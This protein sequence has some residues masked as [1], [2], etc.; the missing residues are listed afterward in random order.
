MRTRPLALVLLLVL[1]CGAGDAQG[2]GEAIRPWYVTNIPDQDTELAIRRGGE[3]ETIYP[4]SYALLV[5]QVNY[6][7]WDR[8]TAVPGEIASLTKA[9]ERQR[10]K[11]E[12]H[13][14]LDYRSLRAVID[15]F[16]QTRG[17]E[18]GSRLVIYVSGHGWSRINAVARPMGYILPVDAPP[19]DAPEAELAAKALPMTHFEAWAKAPDPRHMLFV[20][21]SCF[22]GAFFGF[23]G[24]PGTTSPGSGAP[25]G[26]TDWTLDENG[27]LVPPPPD[28]R[29]IE[30][31]DY[32]DDEM[33]RSSGRQFLAAG[34]STQTVPGRS[35]LTQ[36]LIGILDDRNARAQSNADYWTTADEFGPWIRH[37]ATDLSRRLYGVQLPPRPVYG[38]LPNDSFYQQGDMIF[39]RNDLPGSPILRSEALAWAAAEK[40]AVPI[41]AILTKG[42]SGPREAAK[43]LADAK[44]QQAALVSAADAA[45]PA[46]AD[47]LTDADEADLRRLIDALLLD[48]PVRRR[49]AR[50]DLASWLGGLPPSKQA[51]TLER[52]LARFGRKSYRFQ[53]GVSSALVRQK[54]ALALVD[55]ARAGAEF[56]SAL[57]TK[58]GRDP[59]LH[60]VL[61][62]AGTKVLNGSRF[63]F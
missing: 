9:L 7:H 13:F 61:Q 31:S 51:I 18:P 17:V 54:G 3:I 11:V 14:D 58:A 60:S 20:F 41:D 15:D 10:F 57:G 34:D 50:I 24:I 25:V 38:R 2:G 39:A 21:D 12:V 44:R 30:A 32:I 49:Q 40:T 4:R 59:T 22:S 62:A 56:Q 33:V 45:V 48:D 16:M 63:T 42:T 1:L 29:G 23:Q 5:G 46:K 52:L 35:I 36:L 37:N 27:Q 55:P 8:L 19:E 47:V 6:A 26:K 43:A 28:N 53:L